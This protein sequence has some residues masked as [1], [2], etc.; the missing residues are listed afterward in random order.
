MDS[1]RRSPDGEGLR[2]PET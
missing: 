2:D 1:L